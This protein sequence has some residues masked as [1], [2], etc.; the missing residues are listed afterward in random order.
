MTRMMFDW[1]IRHKLTVMVLGT[2]GVLIVLVA[3]MLTVERYISYHHSLFE[4]TGALAGV[5][6]TNSKTAFALQDRVIGQE[7]LGALKAEKDVVLA[8][9]F[10]SEGTNFAIYTKHED[11]GGLSGIDSICPLEDFLDLKTMQSEKRF[12]GRFFDVVQPV[13][14]DQKILGHVAIRTDLQTKRKRLGLFVTAMF[15]VCVL[16]FVV[17]WIVCKRLISIIV[18]PITELAH[19]VNKVSGSQDYT[20][21]VTKHCTDE[22]GELIDGFNELLAQIHKKERQFTEQQLRLEEL[23]QKRT[24]ELETSKNRLI[25]EVEA[26]RAAEN[27]LGQSEKMAAIGTLVGRAAHDLNNIL[28]GVVSYPELLLMD[29]PE[30]SKS[31]VPLETI[32]ASGKKATA[33]VQDLLTLA[34]REITVEEKV[35]I[36]TLAEEYI[37]SPECSELLTFHPGVQIDLQVHHESPVVIGSPFHLA[38][39][40]MNLVANAAEAIPEKGTIVITIDRLLLAEAPLGAKDCEWHKGEY[41]VLAIADNGVGIPKKHQGRIFEPFYSKKEMGRSGTGLGMAVAW[42]TIEDHGGFL[43]LE[44]KENKGTTIRI[45]IPSLDHKEKAD[46]TIQRNVKYS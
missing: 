17:V 12:Q 29:L 28:S 43:T 20:M 13:F 18:V 3:I 38:K 10:T 23:V 15:S 27:Q 5:I 1:R 44:S 26:R 11:T 25:Q 39:T 36:Q 19:A 35:N 8:C 16:F 42:G 22:V 37:A 7:I 33:I 4:D 9:L 30:D 32:Y 34:R 14:V 31:R 24:M 2:S 45:F 46:V 6:G 41:V 40:V 21:R